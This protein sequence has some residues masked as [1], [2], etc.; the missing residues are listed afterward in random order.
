MSAALGTAEPCPTG[1]DAYLDTAPLAPG[2]TVA[3]VAASGLGT[4]ERVDYAVALLESWGLRVKLGEHLL[5]GHPRASYLSAPDAGR[6]HDLVAAWCD[7]EVDAVVTARGGY[8]A[9][10]LLD[11]IDWE[12]MRAA[13][14]RR[15]GR[16]KLLTG[17]SDVTALHEAFR[18]HLDV[19]TL[20][21]PMVAN[22]VFANSEFIRS[23][24]HRWLFQP[25]R[26]RSI[27]GPEAEILQPGVARGRL[28]GG[29]LSL[30]S[31]SI[32]APEFAVPEGSLLFLEDVD[33]DAYSIDNLLVQLARSGRLSAASGL[34]LGSWHNCAPLDEVKALFVEYLD[35][36][37]GGLDIPVLWQQGFGHDPNA[38]S[39]P[40]NVDGV[41]DLSGPE[42]L[43]TVAP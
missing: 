18:V 14:V 5:D 25:W 37:L 1:R 32:G 11:G 43:L 9:M 30:V 22:D 40:M 24:V 35:E 26:G 7:P 3:L 13:S 17:S 12:A 8:G 21:C 4:R 15:G 41:L 31:A 39:V 2:D 29:T 10:R 36:Y 34:V 6:R 16:P 23:D 38:L 42:A 19:P 20:F 33:E 27:V 28:T